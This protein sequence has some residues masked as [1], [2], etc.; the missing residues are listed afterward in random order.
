MTMN[1]NQEKKQSQ[2]YARPQETQM[3]GIIFIFSLQVQNNVPTYILVRFHTV[4]QWISKLGFI[5][6]YQE[7]KYIWRFQRDIKRGNTW[8]SKY[9]KDGVID[10]DSWS[11]IP[12][13]PGLQVD[14]SLLTRTLPVNNSLLTGTPL[15]RHRETSQ[16]SWKAA[17]ALLW[18]RQNKRLRL[19]FLIKPSPICYHWPDVK[20]KLLETHC[21][22]K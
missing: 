21:D 8:Q 14:N 9:I 15:T 3:K 4:S 12:Y 1:R 10:Q 18:H 20:F 5:N 13:W 17:I 22:D 11:I 6:N 7:S 19:P 16:K 2:K